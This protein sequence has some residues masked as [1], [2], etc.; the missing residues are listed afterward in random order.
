MAIFQALKHCSSASPS[1]PTQA[2]NFS[3]PP[4]LPVSTGPAVLGLQTV[5]QEASRHSPAPFPFP[6]CTPHSSTA[7]LPNAVVYVCYF[8][9]HLLPGSGNKQSN[10]ANITF[11]V[12]GII[13]LTECQT[14]AVK[15]TWIPCRGTA[16]TRQS[17]RS[18]QGHSQ[19]LLIF[20][21]LKLLSSICN[22]LWLFQA[23]RGLE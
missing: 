12:T 8:Q 13:K 14:L 17:H 23:R 21:I 10:S 19:R 6:L 18:T 4:A 11:R 7:H 20:F 16:S 3:L 22:C 15:S 2:P 1:K 5:K 9:T